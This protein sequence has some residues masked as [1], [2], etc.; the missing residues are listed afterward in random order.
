MTRRLSQV[1]DPARGGHTTIVRGHRTRRKTPPSTRV[2]AVIRRAGRRNTTRGRARRG[3]CSTSRPLA[4]E[5]AS[6]WWP[7]RQ[8]A[9]RRC[10]GYRWAIGGHWA[11]TFRVRPRQHHTG[12][13]AAARSERRWLPTLAGSERHPRPS[14][15]WRG[16]N[17]SSPDGLPLDFTRDTRRPL[18]GDAYRPGCKPSAGGEAEVPMLRPV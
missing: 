7:T 8:P 16:T 3:D 1:D 10:H 11:Y 15:T 6:I 14:G 13:C 12:L 9:Q 17:V 2:G 5:T 18:G 4:R